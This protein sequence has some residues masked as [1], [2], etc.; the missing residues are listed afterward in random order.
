MR[1]EKVTLTKNYG[2]ILTGFWCPKCKKRWKYEGGATAAHG[3]CSWCG[4][5]TKAIYRRIENMAEC[6]ITYPEEAR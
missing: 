1:T 6:Y 4:T 3:Y 5:P 2:H